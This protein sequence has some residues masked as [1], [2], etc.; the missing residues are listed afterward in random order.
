MLCSFEYV[1]ILKVDNAKMQKL[2]SPL[3]F[4][5]ALKNYEENSKKHKHCE[6]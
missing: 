4:V 6:D 3:Y 1:H 2:A 5:K